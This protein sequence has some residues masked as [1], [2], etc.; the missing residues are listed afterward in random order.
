MYKGVS[1]KIFS[2]C[3]GDD[4]LTGWDSDTATQTCH[5]WSC[6]VSPCPCVSAIELALGDSRQCVQQQFGLLEVRG[7]KALSEP[8]VY[9]RQELLRFYAL[10]L[11]LPQPTQA[12]RGAQLQRFRL[13][14]AGYGEGLVQTFFSLRVVVDRQQ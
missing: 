4:T 14:A 7:V 1:K 9:L 3:G 10:A 6:S 2:L 5:R 8:A 13:L 12:H 11:L